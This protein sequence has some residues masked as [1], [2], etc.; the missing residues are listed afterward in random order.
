MTASCDED[1]MA[2]ATIR[3]HENPCQN[4]NRNLVSENTRETEGG[5]VGRS[6]WKK[7]GLASGG[8]RGVSVAWDRVW[9]FLLA[10]SCLDAEDNP[11]REEQLLQTPGTRWISWLTNLVACGGGRSETGGGKV[12]SLGLW[13]GR[14]C[15]GGAGKP[16]SREG[17]ITR[18]QRG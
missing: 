18:A 17:V 16:S 15:M 9:G 11:A 14:G 10:I 8:W 12:P 4:L 13:E 3:L 5:R 1:I 2:T 7:G 6:G